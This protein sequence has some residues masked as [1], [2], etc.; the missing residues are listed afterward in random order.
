MTHV[1]LPYYR[2]SL[3]DFVQRK[4]IIVTADFY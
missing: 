1:D 3:R 2:H 4:Q